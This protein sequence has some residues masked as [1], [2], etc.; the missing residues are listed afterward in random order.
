MA[1][2][3]SQQAR[4]STSRLWAVVSRDGVT[5]MIQLRATL[6]TT[7][8]AAA[9]AVHA[10]AALSNDDD[11]DDDDDDTVTKLMTMT[12]DYNDDDNDDSDNTDNC[13][14]DNG[15]DGDTNHVTIMTMTEMMMT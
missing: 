14:A 10:S 7:V 6:P 11:D 5:T 3:R 15:F 8:T 9:V 2:S 12:Y 1:V 13:D 4:L